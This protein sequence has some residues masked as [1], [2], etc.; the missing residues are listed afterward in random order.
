M[1]LE[2]ETVKFTNDQQ[3]I[4][5]KNAV[6]RKMVA[7]GWQVSSESIESGHIKGEEVCCGAAICLPLGALAGRTPG[8]IVVTYARE[9]RPV[10]GHVAC[11]GCG[12]QMPSAAIFC[13]KCGTRLG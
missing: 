5:R 4:A 6:T 12:S 9:I 8:H 3:G 10:Q 7:Q 1:P 13:R 2:Y 11:K